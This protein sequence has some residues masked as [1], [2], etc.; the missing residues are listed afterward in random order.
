MNDL[1]LI[2]KAVA[3]FLNFSNPINQKKIPVVY[4][5]PHRAFATLERLYKDNHAATKNTKKV[6]VPLP[7][8]NFVITDVAPD[9]T[10]NN[11]NSPIIRYS[12]VTDPPETVGVMDQG[13][14]T[15]LISYS[16]DIWTKTY[17]VLYE[18][19]KQ[20]TNKFILQ[21]SEITVDFVDIGTKNMYI[22]LESI[23][24]ASE[25]EAGEN[26][27]KL[28]LN[29]TLQVKGVILR[30]ITKYKTVLNIENNYSTI[31]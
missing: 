8:M 31:P 12:S 13:F 11:S 9:P 18:I 20:L 30:E 3:R 7:A 5:A 22:T 10:R 25:L 14:T 26:D 4:A 6:K 16:L 21:V 23:S 29:A 15:V 2:N 17:D 24:P 1:S 27:R 19:Q 28:R